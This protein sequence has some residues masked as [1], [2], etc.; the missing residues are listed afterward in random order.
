[1]LF[2]DFPQEIIIQIISNLNGKDIQSFVQCHSSIFKR[3]HYES[4]WFELCKLNGI[5]YC[6][7]DISWKELFCSDQLSE[8]CPHLNSNLLNTGL[9]Q[10][11]KKL[12]WF[13]FNQKSMTK[14][15]VLCLHPL[16]DFTSKFY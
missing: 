4:F 11:K 12:L 3:S 14:D 9:L 1:M 8:M 5:G 6:H 16:C 7:P 13:I 10:E 15:Y 2:Q